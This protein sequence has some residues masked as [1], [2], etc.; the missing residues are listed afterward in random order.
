MI[1]FS[2]AKSDALKFWQPITRFVRAGGAASSRPGS[3]RADVAVL[4]YVMFNIMSSRW[5]VLEKCLP[6][7]TGMV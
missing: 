6:V 7:L 2:V 5:L 3:S 1:A 4:C